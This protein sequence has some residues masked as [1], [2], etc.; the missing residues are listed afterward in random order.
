MPGVRLRAYAQR[1]IHLLSRWQGRQGREIDHMDGQLRVLDG[2]G[3]APNALHRGRVRVRQQPGQHATAHQARSPCNDRDSVRYTRDPLARGMME[4][5]R[6]LAVRVW[7][8]SSVGRLDPAATKSMKCH[9]IWPL[10]RCSSTLAD[11]QINE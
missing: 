8:F 2:K 10:F 1:R 4:K 6:Y 7:S 11:I 5:R 9:R 3:F